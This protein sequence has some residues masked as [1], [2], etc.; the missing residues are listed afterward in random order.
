MPAVVLTYLEVAVRV[1]EEIAWFE[2]AVDDVGAVDV[3][4][5]TQHLIDEELTEGKQ[6][7]G[8]TVSTAKPPTPL[9]PVHSLCPKLLPGSAHL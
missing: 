2:V 7:H 5:T 6:A 8:E 4:Q 9:Y 1:D 3:L